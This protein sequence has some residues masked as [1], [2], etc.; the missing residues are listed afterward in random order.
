MKIKFLDRVGAM[1]ALLTAPACPICLPLLVAA[2]STVGLGFLAP[3]GGVMRYAFQVFVGLSFIG[4]IMAFLN[5]RKTIPLAVGTVS[6]ILIF[7]ALYIKFI[8]SLIYTGLSGLLAAALLNFIENRRCKRCKTVSSQQEV[9]LRSKIKCPFCGYVKEE[10]M[11]LD[12]CQHFYECS[13][14]RKILQ[15]RDGDC[16]VFCSYGSTKCPPKQKS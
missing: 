11:S 8:P 14:C 13:N 16:C 15:P 10:K 4:G 9:V 2:G 3:Y 12:S 7:F 6:P 5:H 1:G